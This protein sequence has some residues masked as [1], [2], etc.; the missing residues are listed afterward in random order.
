MQFLGLG[1]NH[2]T[3]NVAS[4]EAFAALL[5]QPEQ[6][7]ASLWKQGAIKECMVLST[8][9][10][11]ELY[12]VTRCHHAVR[13]WL[14]QRKLQD[15]RLIE[16]NLY[17]HQDL[18]LVKHLMGVASG[19]DSMII[20]E[21][22]IFG[23][24]KQA[25]FRAKTNGWIGE[26][27]EKLFPAVF[28]TAKLV[29]SQTAINRH[30]MT[31][32]YAVVQLAKTVIDNLSQSCVLLLGAGETIELIAQ[33]LRRHG[34]GR[35]LIVNRSLSRA[36]ALANQVGAVP[37]GLDQLSDA[38]KEADFVVTATA[39]PQPLITPAQLDPLSR[40]RPLVMVDLAVPRDIDPAVAAVKHISLFDLDDLQ[41]RLATNHETR[42]AAVAQAQAIIDVQALQYQRQLRV[43]EASAMIR[44]YRETMEQ[45]RDQELQK[46]LK[47]LTREHADPALVLTEFARR[48]TNTFMHQP[49]RRLREAV[50]H[51]QHA[52]IQFMRCLYELD[53]Q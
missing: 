47:A 36:H 15:Q 2:Q 30:P 25:F 3:A 10:R 18:A 5:D 45:Q 51:E 11:T 4:R 48:L 12:A 50:S 35:L 26:R 40:D 28:E 53:E 1:M 34:V 9:N 23:Q 27:F 20:G 29:R 22:Q 41:A 32:T 44:R 46:A 16:A 37:M 6:S 19:V 17:E 24:L 39:A 42:Q 52:F 43:M 38:L 7:L 21:P 31:L 14:H 8:C 49:T 33:Y 13:E